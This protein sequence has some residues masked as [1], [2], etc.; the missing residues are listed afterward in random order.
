MNWNERAFNISPSVTKYCIFTEVGVKFMSGS[1][2]CADS[3]LLKM[4]I[5]SSS[6]DLPKIYQRF[7]QN[8]AI[9]GILSF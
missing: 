6:K 9:F 2:M 1:S 7:T 4:L 5:E 3:K 8:K